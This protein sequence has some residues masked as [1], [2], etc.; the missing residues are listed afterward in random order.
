MDELLSVERLKEILSAAR[1]LRV[2]VV[3]DFTLD[4]YWFADMPRSVISR[5]TPLFPR[6]VVRE[7]YSCGG[8]ANVAWNLAALKPAEV[9]AFTVFGHDWRGELMLKALREAG[10]DPRDALFAQDWSTPFFGKV[11]LM[12]GDLQ[13][14]DA[15]LDFIN[16]T[17]LALET[18]EE[19]LSR[20]ESAMP[21]LD[22]L[23]VADY[24][25]IGVITPGV[26]EGLNRLA[27]KAGTTIFTVDSRERIG[28]F[29]AMLRK[30]N[31]IEAARWLFPDQSPEHMHLEDFAEAALY[32]Q[33]DCG[34]PLFITL[35]EK[36]CLVMDG[37][38]SHL[39]PA[40][41]VPPPVDTVG[42]GDT[43]LAALTMGMAAGATPVEAARLGHIASAV[44]VRKLGITGSASP[45]EILAV[46]ETL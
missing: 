37:G 44:T 12:N 13:Q 26:L 15:R 18:E 17:G 11:M 19:L 34:C 7:R 16:T 24:Q 5:E 42:A 46:A 6:P 23:V 8:A 14:E 28:Q 20:L 3:G 39:V 27:E 32:P 21:E 31:R 9:R 30:P 40:V 33:V 36:G 35:G 2:A 1:K 22:A 29:Q 43:F 38:E 45:E 41:K 10:V 4:G 25:A